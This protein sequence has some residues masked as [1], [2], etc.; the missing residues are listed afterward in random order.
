LCWDEPESCSII[1]DGAAAVVLGRP[2]Q[3]E[4]CGVLN[5]RMETYSNGAHLAEIRGG[6]SASHASFH[7]EK[8]R[9]EYLF[10]MDGKGIFRM[11]AEILPE[12]V[13][14]LIAP[15]GLKITDFNMVIPH[16]ASLPA[17]RLMRRR[18]GVAEA[19]WLTWA[20][21]VGNT[22]AASIPMGLHFALEQHRVKRGDHLLLIGTS[23][24]L[25]LGGV[26]LQL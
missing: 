14:R 16:Q 18:L 1:G 21:K 3:G 24:G 8:T 2:A 22:I 9:S 6:G 17:L 5:A 4:S 12:F 15:T 25:S 19:N 26:A 13:N 10:H 23:A 20:D 7:N 11:A